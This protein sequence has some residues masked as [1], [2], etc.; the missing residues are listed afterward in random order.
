[1]FGLAC[2]HLARLVVNDGYQPDLV[3]SIA[4][5]G[6]FPAGALSYALEVKN[7]QMVNVEFYTADE[8]HGDVPVMLAP[9]PTAAELDGRRVLIVDDVADTGATLALVRDFC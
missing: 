9:I 8:E 3:L 5:G 6:L 1:M 7:L 2:R 4:R